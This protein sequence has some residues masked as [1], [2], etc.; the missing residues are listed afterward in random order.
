M[1]SI[2]VASYN[3]E[4][5]IAQTIKSMQ[6]QTYPHWELWVVDD[7]STDQTAAVVKP[8]TEQDSRV[9]YVYQQNAGKCTAR[10]KGASLAQYP[11]LAFC[12]ADDQW[13]PNKLEL[14]LQMMEQRQADV[15][16]TA[17]QMIDENSKPGKV[18]VK[19]P[20]MFEGM[21]GMRAMFDS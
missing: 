14:Q 1:V 8:F 17:Y 19:Q 18:V 10:N 16:F 9:H 15:V 5:Y 4:R 11:L 20:R 13:I 3:Y 7:G 6:A 2:V 12:D 21:D